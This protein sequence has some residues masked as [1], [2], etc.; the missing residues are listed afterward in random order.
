[1]P[2][3][4]NPPQEPA[5][6]QPPPGGEAPDTGHESTGLLA[7]IDAGEL[8]RLREQAAQFAEMRDSYLRTAADFQNLRKRME[9]DTEDRARRKV[10]NLLNSVLGAIDELDRA[11]ATAPDSPVVQGIRLIRDILNSAAVSEGIR[12]IP[13]LGLPFDP[14]LHEALS[15]MPSDK[16]AGTILSEHR[17][18]YTWGDRV[19][20]PS[21]VVVAAAPKPDGRAGLPCTPTPEC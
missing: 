14:K 6:P 18:G 13:T 20:R 10:E 12:E 8:L 7:S 4:T 17:K 2:D 11:C 21:Q 9:R 1:M 3:E 16:P 19:L 15:S 5:T